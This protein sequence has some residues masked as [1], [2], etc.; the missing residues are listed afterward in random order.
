M[1]GR[2]DVKITQ[3]TDNSFDIAFSANGDFETVE[4]FDTALQMSILS[5]MRATEDEVPVPQYRRGW[6]GNEDNDFPIGST[7]WLYDQARRTQTTLNDIESAAQ[8]AT[9]WF[10]DENLVDEIEA[11]TTFFTDGIALEVKFTIKDRPTEINLFNLWELT[12]AQNAA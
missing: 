7:I 10:L 4:G 11:T 9:Q 5:E 3:Q 6:I 12:G 8:V 1:T 2:T